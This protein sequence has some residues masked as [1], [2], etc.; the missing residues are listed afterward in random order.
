[1]PEREAPLAEREAPLVLY[2]DDDAGN[3]LVFEESF[4]SRFVVQTVGSPVQALEL[5]AKQEI[6]VVV[7]DQR[8]PEMSGNQLL[9]IVKRDYPRIVRLVI[10]A[11][12]DLDPIL[13]AVNRGLVSGYVIKPWTHGELE[14]LLT[15][16]LDTYRVGKVSEQAQLRL[17]ECERLA[18]VGMLMGAMTHDINRPLSYIKNNLEPLRT[19]ARS[20]PSLAELVCRHGDMLTVTDRNNLDNLAEDLEDIVGEITKGV[21]FIEQLIAGLSRFLEKGREARVVCAE[22]LPT[23]EFAMSVVRHAVHAA[24]GVLEVE[25]PE[26]LPPIAMGGTELAQVLIN[27]VS[28]SLQALDSGGRIRVA[29]EVEGKHVLFAVSDNGCGMSPEILARSGS[30]FFTTREGGTGLGLPQC[31]RIVEGTGG[32]LEIRSEQGSGTTV[33]FEVPI[34]VER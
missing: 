8:M 34:V 22:P 26:A 10:T 16:A 21:S 27:L 32:S 25:T 1:M 7:T 9:E 11:Y 20:A 4:G 6:G 14:K 29:I 19:A 5:L 30:P 31:H 23:V 24:K 28:N 18:T 12:S 3:C 13:Q 17:Q 33:S 15:W 2:V